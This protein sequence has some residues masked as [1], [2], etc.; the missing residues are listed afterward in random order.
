M[1][2]AIYKVSNVDLVVRQSSTGIARFGTK[3]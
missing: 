1:G 3:V 2:N